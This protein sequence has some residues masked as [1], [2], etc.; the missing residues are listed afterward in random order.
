MKTDESEIPTTQLLYTILDIPAA[1]S[2]IIYGSGMFFAGFALGVIR[3]LWLIPKFGEVQ[4]ALMEIPF[5]LLFCWYLSKQCLLAWYC[6]QVCLSWTD[7]H[8][9]INTMGITAFVTLILLE[10]FMSVTLLHKTLGEIEQDLVS[11]K[12]TVGLVAQV[13][14]SSF[15]MIQMAV[16]DRKTV[17]ESHLE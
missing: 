15:P 6:C 12:G 13:I 2:G 7:E 3:I 14:A 8:T 4:S 1:M 17:E 11:T 9:D 16:Q 5:M 10:T